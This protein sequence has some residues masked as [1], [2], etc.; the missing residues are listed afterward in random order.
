ML[1][2]ALNVYRT[3]F[4]PSETLDKP[5]VM[6]AA[7][8]CA[9]ESDAEAD[10]LRSS[11]VLAF[12]RLRSGNPGKLPRPVENIADQIP[13]EMMGQIKHAMSVSAAGSTDTVRTQLKNIIEK[14]KP[15]ELIV[16]GM[17]HDHAKRLKSFETVAGILSEMR[18]GLAAA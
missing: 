10:Y 8:V 1:E 9:A 18:E 17:I 4:R 15:D 7:G 6:V 5:H 3:T 13:P 16:T 11:Q 12:A 14:Y 2:Q